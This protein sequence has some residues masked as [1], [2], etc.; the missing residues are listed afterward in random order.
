MFI[1]AHCM[2][3]VIINV[4]KGTVVGFF[5]AFQN[6]RIFAMDMAGK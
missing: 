6:G 3:G 4:F 5:D 1:G 2:S